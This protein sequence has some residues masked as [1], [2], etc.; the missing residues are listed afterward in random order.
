MRTHGEESPAGYGDHNV[1]VTSRAATLGLGA[2]FVGAST[3]APLVLKTTPSDL[4]LF[5]WPSTETAVS[6]H[7]LL[8]YSAQFSGGVFNDNGPFGLIPVIPAVALANALGWAGSLAGRAALTG[9]IVSLFVLLLA[10]QAVQLIGA[11]RGGVRRPLRVAATILLAPALW[12]GIL[13]YGHVEQPVEMCL[14]LLAISWSLRN[15]RALTGIA[16]GAAILTRTI[17]GFCAIPLILAPLASRR[18][19][20][21]AITAVAMIITVCIGLA[22]FILAD[23]STVLRALVTNRGGLDIGSGSF[24]ILARHAS[25]AG[26]VREFDVYIG[27]AVAAALVAIT[28]RRKPALATTH[29]GLTGLLTVASCFLPLFAK[30]VFPYYLVEPYV[31]SAIWW[32]ARPGTAFNWR[33]LI[34]LSLTVDVFVVKAALLSPLSV[35]G[36]VAGVASSAVLGVAAALVTVDLLRADVDVAASPVFRPGTVRRPV[37]AA[38]EAP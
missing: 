10:Y 13:D 36:A 2:A 5:F 17:A 35:W 25:W 23:G 32:L 11:A 14:L 3:L 18:I 7:P 1:A 33:A 20:P 19:R 26:L 21:M 30:S 12:I 24:W 8:I 6:G 37:P 22:P 27:A 34:P 38:Q 4:D 9:A 15:R 29:V 31:F 16:L 28:L